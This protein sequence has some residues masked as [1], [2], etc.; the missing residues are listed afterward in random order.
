MESFACHY[1]IGQDKW[2]G[3]CPLGWS[4]TSC[5]GTGLDRCHCPR[6]ERGNSPRYT[7]SLFCAIVSMKD[8]ERGVSDSSQMAEEAGYLCVASERGKGT[9]LLEDA[10]CV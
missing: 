3:T 4:P 2:K 5:V 8:S 9:F 10:L 7:G 6:V 1:H